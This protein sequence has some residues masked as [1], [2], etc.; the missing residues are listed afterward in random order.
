LR[1]ESIAALRMMAGSNSDRD[2]LFEVMLNISP[3]NSLM[4]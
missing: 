4:S 1:N 2:L 3:F